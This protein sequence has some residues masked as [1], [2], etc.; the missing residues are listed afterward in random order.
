MPD[1][2]IDVA[3]MLL[4][5]L[6]GQE[7]FEEPPVIV[8]LADVAELSKQHDTL[9]HDGDFARSVVDLLDADGTSITC[10][11]QAGVVFNWDKLPLV[12]K[13]G[14]V[15]LQQLINPIANNGVKEQKVELLSNFGTVACLVVMRQKMWINIVDWRGWMFAPMEDGTA[16]DIVEDDVKLVG[17]S[18]YPRLSKKMLACF[19]PLTFLAIH[20]GLLDRLGAHAVNTGRR[21][22]SSWGNGP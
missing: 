12:V 2:L 19:F 10:V 11:N 3:D 15:L 1:K 5:W 21:L 14:P 4:V 22:P 17:W 18:G 9:A 8:D 13:D 20:I 16:L 6:R 7:C